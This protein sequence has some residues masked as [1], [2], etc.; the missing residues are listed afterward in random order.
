VLAE[1][2]NILK[3]G[4]EMAV[5][6]NCGREIDRGEDILS[7][8]SGRQP[9]CRCPRPVARREPSR[10]PVARRETSRHETTQN[11]TYVSPAPSIADQLA[12]LAK[13]RKEGS[14]TEQE[15]QT[16]KTRLISGDKL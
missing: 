14:L 11:I 4:V 2:A 6:K 13:L 9:S 1:L 3:R 8:G 10:R 5:C 12:V 16:L 15:F 7:L